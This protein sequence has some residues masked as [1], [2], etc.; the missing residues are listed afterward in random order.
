MNLHNVLRMMNWMRMMQ[1][2]DHTTPTSQNIKEKNVLFSSASVG[3]CL[4]ICWRMSVHFLQAIY[5]WSHEVYITFTSPVW[6]FFFLP[7]FNRYFTK[8]GSQKVFLADVKVLGTY[9]G[10]QVYF[11]PFNYIKLDSKFTLYEWNV[12][13]FLWGHV[14]HDYFYG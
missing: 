12:S 14:Q 9:K 2:F 5:S 11:T 3:G 4:V 1:L 8:A 13:F 6:A 7:H 10:W